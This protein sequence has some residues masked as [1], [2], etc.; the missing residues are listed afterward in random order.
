MASQTHLVPS[1]SYFS[2]SKRYMMNDNSGTCTS[3]SINFDLYGRVHHPITFW[4]YA[5]D[6][7]MTARVE[8][9]VRVPFGRC[10]SDLVRLSSSSLTYPS[11][12][13]SLQTAGYQT[14]QAAVVTV[15]VP[16][17]LKSKC[18]MRSILFFSRLTEHCLACSRP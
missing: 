16:R 10:P 5:Q 12:P 3:D 7:E 18:E 1:S 11:Q 2:S 9:I 13:S 15:F 6:Q 17:A 4:P 14:A 8:N